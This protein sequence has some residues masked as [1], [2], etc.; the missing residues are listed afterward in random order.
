MKKIIIILLSVVVFLTGCGQDAELTKFKHEIDQFC[1]NISKLDTAIN[2]IQV[3]SDETSLNNA[4]DELLGYLDELDDEFKKLANI[5]FPEEFE[6]L[7]DMSDEASEYMT[8]AVSAYHQA[9]GSA[10]YNESL[11]EYAKENY[12]RAYKRVQII[13][14]FLHGE[15]PTDADLIIK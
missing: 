7:E 9:F 3:S 11:G 10:I 8:E 4:T 14:T 15:K 5:T 12:S 2:K 13:I 6:Y 1:T